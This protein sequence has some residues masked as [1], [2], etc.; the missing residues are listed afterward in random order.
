MRAKLKMITEDLRRRMHWPVP[1]LGKW[2]GLVVKGYFNYHAV[3]TNIRALATFRDEIIRRWLRQLRRR[4][5]RNRLMWDQMVELA[6]AWLPRPRIT[7][8]WPRQRV[9]VKHPR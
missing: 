9:I 8:S 6:A 5:Q 1:E 4:S 3:P 7:L 2:L